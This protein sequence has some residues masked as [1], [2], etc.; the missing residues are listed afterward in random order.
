MTA[1]P[2]PHPSVRKRF[3]LKPDSI[4][5]WFLVV[6]AAILLCSH[7]AVLALYARDRTQALEAAGLRQA[8]ARMAAAVETVGAAP[9]EARRPI[10]HAMGGPDFRLGVTDTPI[11][12]RNSAGPLG[13]VLEGLLTTRLPEGTELG[14][15]SRQS[16]CAAPAQFRARCT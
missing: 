8:A 4:T 12:E 7:L 1:A 10:V 3:R 11:A 9:A 5:G 6:L 14:R 13:R 16:P 15:R 2:V